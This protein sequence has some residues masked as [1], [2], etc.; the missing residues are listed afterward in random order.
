M[1]GSLVVF[2]SP[3]NTLY[4]KFSALTVCFLY[5]SLLSSG[6]DTGFGEPCSLPQTS[7]FKESCQKTTA[8]RSEDENNP[9]QEFKATCA[10]D[11]Y[12]T[13]QTF[14]CLT[15]RGS[16]SYCSMQCTTNADCEGGCCCPLFGDCSCTDDLMSVPATPLDGPKY[17]VR[18]LDVD[19]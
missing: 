6:C 13:C 8:A 9:E 19:P 5:F 14:S 4:L 17:C 11:N 1:N 2:A 18:R 10:V 15:Y 3:K 7:Q 12:P 16:D